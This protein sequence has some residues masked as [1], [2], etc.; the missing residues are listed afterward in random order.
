MQR[1][2]DR[3]DTGTGLLFR[4][5]AANLRKVALRQ[6]PQPRLH[7]HVDVLEVGAELEAAVLDL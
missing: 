6:G 7:I 5:R 1:S 3:D 2:I 4:D